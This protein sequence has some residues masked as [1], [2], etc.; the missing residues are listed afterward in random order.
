MEDFDQLWGQI[1]E[2][3]NVQNLVLANASVLVLAEKSKMTTQP[4]H[5][6]QLN[7]NTLTKAELKSTRMSQS[8]SGTVR[9]KLALWPATI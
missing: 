6:L 8:M 1:L 5:D 7:G 3:L 9:W 4:L 2:K